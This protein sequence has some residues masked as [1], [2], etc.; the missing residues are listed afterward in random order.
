MRSTGSTHPICNATVRPQTVQ[1]SGAS[2]MCRAYHR[3]RDA[4]EYT[5]AMSALRAMLSAIAL[6]GI[7]AGQQTVSFP[8]RDGGSISAL[9]YGESTRA[10]VLAHGGRFNKESWEP[11]AR[12][13]AAAGFRALSIDFRGEGQSRAGTPGPLP[14]EGRHLD[15]LAAIHYLR[16]SGA[17]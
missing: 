9:L 10:V 8:T 1:C 5:D 12:A 14:D 17:K 6:A 11:Q 2:S 15:I 13:L 16:E 3:P 4:A 7:A